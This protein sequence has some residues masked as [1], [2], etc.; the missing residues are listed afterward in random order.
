M[1]LRE[2]SARANRFLSSS[3]RWH[4]SGALLSL[5]LIGGMVQ[6]H[7]RADD[8]NPE[9]Q[10]PDVR[11]G[12]AIELLK[13]AATWEA[14]RLETQRVRS[15]QLERIH[16]L[17]SWLPG[18]V[19]MS[20]IEDQIETLVEDSGSVLHSFE[21]SGEQSGTRVA[22]AQCTVRVQGSFASICSLVD[23]LTRS[24]KPVGCARIRLH[25]LPE[26]ESKKLL[27]ATVESDGEA[28][29]TVCEAILTLRVPYAAPGTLGGR[30]LVQRG[31]Q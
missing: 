11:P 29:P 21:S 7:R 6:M 8:K 28:E 15:A 16:S 30:L 31:S 12:E 17:A 2:P 5:L 20:E 4:L 1:K 22:V 14:A 10:L 27:P 13:Q 26:S 9:F 23:Q 19:E 24:E 3:M 18:A 25:R